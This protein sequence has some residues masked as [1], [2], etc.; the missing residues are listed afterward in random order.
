MSTEY[1]RGNP[2]RGI[3]LPNS[4]NELLDAAFKRAKKISPPGGVKLHPLKKVKSEAIESIK[5][6]GE[7]LSNKLYEIVKK[8]PS[9]EKLH[10]FYS[11]IMELWL[12]KDDYKRYIGKIHGAAQLIHKMTRDFTIRIR[13]IQKEKEDEPVRKLIVK[14]KR[15]RKEAYGRI[16]SV[17]KSLE[18][19]IS[20][21]RE[22]VKRMKKLP[23]Y[24]PSLPTIVVAGPPNTG[25]S[26]FVRAVSN[27]KVEIASYP[28]T[29]KNITFGHI[30]FREKDLPIGRAQIADTPGIF[31]RPLEER[32]EIELLAI[33]AIKTIPDIIIFMFD[34]STE[35]A[36]TPEEQIN[37]FK[38]VDSFFGER[39]MVLALNKID[40]ADDNVLKVLKKF[41][42]STSYPVFEISVLK[43][44]NIDKLME[45]IRRILFP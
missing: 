24:D 29:T 8:M 35:A 2:F 44:I 43:R 41:L 23:D 42:V 19:E 6:F 17:I 22:L 12:S 4:T 31:D 9:V 32:N 39:K 34:V 37:V 18:K 33:N 16:S 11:S 5:A 30:E 25:K 21:L 36:L 28:F 40:I 14:V 7:Y 15:V 26:S 20:A 10:P 27:A 38:T 13:S 3:F 45:C 1:Y